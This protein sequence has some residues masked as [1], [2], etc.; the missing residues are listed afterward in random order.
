MNS[1]RLIGDAHGKTD[2][3][4]KIASEAE[5]SIQLGDMGF[6]YSKLKALDPNKHLFIP[7]NH[8]NY[9]AAFDCEY[10]IGCYGG[11][12]NK[13]LN[14]WFFVRG[15]I[16]IDMLARVHEYM[17]GGP[18]TWWYEEELLEEELKD[19]VKLYAKSKPR[20]ML[21]HDCPILAKK[22]MRN[23]S[24]MLDLTRFGFKKRDID[25]R[26]QVYL[27]KMFDAHEPELWVFGHYHRSVD[28]KIGNTRFI[29][30]NELEYIDVDTRNLNIK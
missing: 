27:Q 17:N 1:V 9:D 14:D 11:V 12:P 4:L 28:F 20:V 8:E 24:R 21:T 25:C 3:Y 22:W 2:Q 6:D 19:A 29:C 26:T 13:I 15:A 5:Y 30:L 16:S 18:K 23:K 7:G 10:N